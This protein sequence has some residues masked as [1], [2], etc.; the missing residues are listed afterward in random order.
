MSVGR[1]VYLLR[2]AHQ[3]SLREAAIRTGVSHT[4]IARI[5]KGVI[6]SSFHYTLDKIAAGYGVPVEYLLNGFE[7]STPPFF[8][9]LPETSS[10]Q[11]RRYLIACRS[12][13]KTVIHSLKELGPYNKLMKRAARAGIQPQV[14]EKALN[15]LIHN[16]H[17][18]RKNSHN[19]KENSQKNESP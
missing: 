6:T 3:E 2:S 4:T 8:L 18:S 5:E 10:E 19:N 1:R 16:S 15:R 11:R 14:L 9:P 17:N 12:N 7:H 13:L